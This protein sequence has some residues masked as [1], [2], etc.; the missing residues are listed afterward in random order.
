MSRVLL[1]GRGPPERG[2]ISAYMV[3]L[4]ESPLAEKHE[5]EMLNLTTAQTPQAGRLT[6]SN[7]KRT[8][9]DTRAVFSQA[10]RADLVHIHTAL[11]PAVTLARASLLC[12]AARLRRRP[13]VI[14]VHSGKVQLWLDGRPRRLLARVLMA[15]ATRVVAVSE[16]A[17]R[18]LSTVVRGRRLVMIENGVDPARFG[19]PSPAKIPP[20]IL[21]V[22]LL[23]PRK[24][25]IDLIEAGRLLENRG[26]AHKIVIVGGTPDEGPEAEEEV[27]TAAR[28]R[29]ALL[30]SRPYA[31]MPEVYREADVFCLPSWWEAMPLTLLEAMATALPVVATSVGDIPRVVE[32]GRSGLLVAPRSPHSL[33]DALARMLSDQATALAMGREAR[34]RVQEFS[35]QRN[36]AAIDL[37]YREI[38]PATETSDEQ[39][40]DRH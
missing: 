17:H 13:V 27:R 8:F 25:V 35:Q 15:G 22:G 9:A 40:A 19:P 21:Y 6:S 12:L 1:V 31:E 39:G 10:R 36:H 37:L 26:I 14:H 24:G 33:A 2:G 18:A 20:V 28:G 7:L 3:S 4:F 38:N 16:G 34:I 30:Q 32:E 29:A 11:V 23:T 5:I